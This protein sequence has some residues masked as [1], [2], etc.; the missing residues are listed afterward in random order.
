MIRSTL[1]TA[2]LGAALFVA[3]SALA[4]GHHMDEARAAIVGFTKGVL[5][6]PEAVAKWLAPEYQ[7]MRL[8]GVGYDRDGYI[9]RGV[10]QISGAPDFSHEDIVETHAGDI[11]VVRYTLRIDEV[12]EGKKIAKRAPRL[13]VFR[14]IDGAWKVVAHSNF[15]AGA[16]K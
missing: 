9:N 11:M 15:G 14:K 16:P 6:G 10:G 12:I 2:A 5:G 7:I 13:T 4:D 1:A 3:P 8:N